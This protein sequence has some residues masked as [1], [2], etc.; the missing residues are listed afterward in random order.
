MWEIKNSDSVSPNTYR[1]S[2]VKLVKIGELNPKVYKIGTVVHPS[3][4]NNIL[5][6]GPEERGR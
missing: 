1:P 2:P 5:V 3:I 6:K 4:L